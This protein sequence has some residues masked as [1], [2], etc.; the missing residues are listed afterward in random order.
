MTLETRA[1]HP[2]LAVEIVG[3]QLWEALDDA[4]TATLRDLYARYGVL[5]FRRQALNEQ[6]LVDFC[7]LL[8]PLE[9]TVRGDWASLAVP[10][11][12]VLSNLKDGL[13]RNIGGLGDGELL[14][15]SDQSYMETPSTGAALYAL[16]LPPEGG[17]TFWVD[18]RAAYAGLPRP[19]RAKITGKR[20]IF[21][22]A[23]RLAGY[24]RESDS[25]ISEET[26]RLTPPVTHALVRAHPE[27]GERSLYLDSTTTIGIDYMDV[28]SGMALLDEVYEA[29]TRDEFVYAHRW[30]VG[31]LVVW[32]N[33]FTMHRR[34]PFDPGARRL[35][36]RMTMTLDKYRHVLPD[37]RLAQSE[38]GMPI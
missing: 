23:K 24:G 25:A 4:T 21:D 27:T 34:T 1:L 11:V 26:R 30:Q 35:M 7:A 17:E 18:L 19:L 38:V 33:G 37:G 36:K 28:T 15:H 20:G 10:E 32:D 12:T 9:R 22:Y 13:G 5:V 16:E 31:D 2:T 3:L 29:A 8:G 6:E 14:W